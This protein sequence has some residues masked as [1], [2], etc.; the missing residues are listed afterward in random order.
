[1]IDNHETF[2][3]FWSVMFSFLICACVQYVHMQWKAYVRVYVH[4]IQ[5]CTERP[6]AKMAIC[7]A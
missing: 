3:T 2:V 6:G 5:C 4:V 7:I 1:V